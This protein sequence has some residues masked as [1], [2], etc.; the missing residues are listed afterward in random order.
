MQKP[1]TFFQ[2]NIDIFAIFNDQIFYDTLTTDI[3]SFEQLG[4]VLFGWKKCLIWSYVNMDSVSVVSFFN[5]DLYF[6]VEWLCSFLCQPWP[7]N[8]FLIN[9]Y[10]SKIK[11]GIQFHHNIVSSSAVLFDDL[12]L[13]FSLM[14]IIFRS[15]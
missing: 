12:D 2:Q 7:Q 10:Y 15:A 1:L 4:P 14:T 5:H 8:L 3:V 9:N 13:Y 6:T 11:P